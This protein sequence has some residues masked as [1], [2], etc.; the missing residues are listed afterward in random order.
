MPEENL[1][2]A[3]RQR[4][5]R[6][7][8]GLL[9]GG[10]VVATV[11]FA[12]PAMASQG[13]VVQ[14]AVTITTASSTSSSTA[15][16]APVTTTEA[17]TTTAPVETT[18]TTAPPSPEEQLRA[19]LAAMTPEEAAAF[20][21]YITPPPPTTTTTAPKPAPTTTAPKPAAPAPKAQTQSSGP[22]NGFLACVRQR[23]SHGQYN[24]NTG[25]GYYGAYQ[26]SQSTWNNTARHAGRG[27][28]VGRAPSSVSPA[29]QDAMAAHLYGWQGRSPWAGPG[30]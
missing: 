3:D 6:R 28:L 23:E 19:K 25:N 18:T 15:V 27:D 30:C 24:I 12:V 20:K 14:S 17:P 10:A 29:D 16:E 9:V 26:F 2:T 8:A 22:A 7:L 1:E 5:V 13:D 21:A 11:A 4:R